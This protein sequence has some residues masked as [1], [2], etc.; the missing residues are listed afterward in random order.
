MPQREKIYA[1]YKGDT[2][3]DVGTKKELSA[4][5]GIGVKTLGYYAAPSRRKRY[6]EEKACIVIRLEEDEE[7]VNDERGRNDNSRL[8]SKRK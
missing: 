3:I 4:R 8:I 1:L 5:L 6:N 2:F 7:E